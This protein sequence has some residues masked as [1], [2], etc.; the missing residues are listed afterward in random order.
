[1]NARGQPS[2][3]PIKLTTL[4]RLSIAATPTRASINTHKDAMTLLFRRNTKRLPQL[5]SKDVAIA[6][7]AISRDGKFC[8]GNVKMTAKLYASWTDVAIKPGGS[9]VV[10]TVFTSFPNDI[11]QHVPKMQ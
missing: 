3:P 5:P 4:S 11:Q 6:R 1:M 2:K 8:N 10:K 9:E 7:V